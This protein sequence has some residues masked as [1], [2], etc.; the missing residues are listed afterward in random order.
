MERPHEAALPGGTHRLE[1]GGRVAE[2]CGAAFLH[3][4]SLADAVVGA[5]RGDL[6]R[7]QLAVRIAARLEQ[8]GVHEIPIQ[9]PVGVGGDRLQESFLDRLSVLRRGGGR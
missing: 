6:Q 8:I 7:D 9:R 1:P 2:Q 4:L 5:G 3:Q